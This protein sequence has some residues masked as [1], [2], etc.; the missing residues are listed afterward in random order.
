MQVI[1]DQLRVSDDGQKMFIDIHVNGLPV[2][3][4]VYLDKLYVTTADN[5][6]ETSSCPPED[7]CFYIHTFGEGDKE[8]HLT[9][10]NFE[11]SYTYEKPNFS[12]DLFF[13]YITCK[14]VGETNPC[15]EVM[16]CEYKQTAVGV[17]FDENLLYQR[18][19]G[20]TKDLADSCSVHQGFTD[21][22]LQWNAFKASVETE[23]WVSAVRF[24]NMLFGNTSDT[25][26][27]TKHCGCNG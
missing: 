21:F 25:G 3:E 26:N 18:V 13:V 12:S 5:V 8:A 27:T 6:E 14:T 23:H 1:F 24:Y 22:I 20:Y 10:P 15:Y 17:T 16:S 2:F 9:L 19:M 4:H 7:K 11:S